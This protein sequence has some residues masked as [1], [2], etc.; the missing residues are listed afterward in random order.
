MRFI[1]LTI[2][3]FLIFS[4]SRERGAEVHHPGGDHDTTFPVVQVNQP[5]MNQQYRNQDTLKIEGNATD[6]GLHAGNIRII[7]EANGN[8]LKQQAFDLHTLNTYNFY[9]THVINVTRA[10]YTIR[11][12]FEDHGSNHTV[13]NIPVKVMP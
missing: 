12:D 3:A 6:I 7:D 10:N 11:V 1:L 9:L 2:V 5:V 8:V 4:C 13:K